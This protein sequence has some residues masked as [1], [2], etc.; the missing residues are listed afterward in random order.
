MTCDNKEFSD[1]THFEMT[2]WE[3]GIDKSF[4]DIKEDA[5]TRYNN[6][7]ARL[8][9]EH[10]TFSGK[11]ILSDTASD[12]SELVALVTQIQDLKKNFSNGK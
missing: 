3:R 5:V 9:K 11:T 4:D 10:K 6:I 1:E 2:Q 8:K 7:C 12:K